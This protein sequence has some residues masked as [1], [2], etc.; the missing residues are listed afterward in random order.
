MIYS[1]V[2]QEPQQKISRNVAKQIARPHFLVIGY[3]NGAKGDNAVG[4]QIANHI[5]AWEAPLVKSMA[6]YQ[7]TPDLVNNLASVDYV[8]FVRP[9]RRSS[10]A[11]TLQVD[12]IFAS[13][14]PPQTEQSAER[15]PSECTHP[16]TPTALLNL[17]QQLY[18]H[19]PQAWLLQI[20]TDSTN[21]NQ[22]LSSTAQRGYDRALRTIEKFFMT[23]QQPA[24]MM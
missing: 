14:K 13:G 22:A 16:C 5:S 2:V 15:S 10:H 17:A 11:G 23:Y 1:S 21:C 7:L 9:C 8:F 12:P 20:P 6:A 18:G 3:G 4:I 19:S 24:E